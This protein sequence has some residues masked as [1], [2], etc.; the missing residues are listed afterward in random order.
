MNGQQ[1]SP[2]TNIDIPANVTPAN[3]NPGKVKVPPSGLA[4]GDSG[5][6]EREAKSWDVNNLP[7]KLARTWVRPPKLVDLP[8][9]RLRD[10]SGAPLFRRPKA[11]TI[12]IPARVDAGETFVMH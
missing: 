2:N 4:A 10:A 7:R 11:P 3:R 12:V 5:Q 9:R 1:R 8:G 6:R